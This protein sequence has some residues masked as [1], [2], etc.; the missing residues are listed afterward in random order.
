MANVSVW[1]ANADAQ[2]ATNV[3][4][5]R[6]VNTQ[7]ATEGQQIFTIS[8][9]TYTPGADNLSVYKNG[10]LQTLTTHYTETSISSVTF[11]SG[12]TAGDVVTFVGNSFEAAVGTADNVAVTVDSLSTTVTKAFSTLVLNS[13]AEL[14]TVKGSVDNPKA[15][16]YGVSAVGDAAIQHY[17]WNAS[18]AAADDG[19]L[20]ILPT[21]HLTNGR[22]LRMPTP[23]K[24]TLTEGALGVPYRHI[25]S[26]AFS[27]GST[28]TTVGAIL[29]S[30]QYD[31]AAQ[32]GC[33]IDGTDVVS[34]ITDS[35]ALGRVLY[36]REGSFGIDSDITIT[37]TQIWIGAGLDKTSITG[38]TGNE[39]ISI[40][41]GSLIIIGI[42]FTNL[43]DVGYNTGSIVEFNSQRCKYT[44][45][46]GV[47]R[48]N[49]VTN[50]IAK[51]VFREN[52]IDASTNGLVAQVNTLQEADVCF[53]VITN[54]ASTD[55]QACGIRLGNDVY[56]AQSATPN[57]GRY[58]LIGNRIHGI[59][60]SN[61]SSSARSFGIAVF[62]D[63]HKILGNEVTDITTS[64]RKLGAEGIYDKGRFSVVEG[65]IC[66]DAVQS[67]QGMITLKGDRTVTSGSTTG[68]AKV[69]RG[70]ICIRTSTGEAGFGIWV[71]S[72]DTLVDGNYCEGMKANTTDGITIAGGIGISSST[73]NN[74]SITNNE[75]RDILAN[76]GIYC[77]MAGYGLKIHNNKIYEVSDAEA[78]ASTRAIGI[79][80][81][82]GA[83]DSIEITENDIKI[84]TT[85]STTNLVGIYFAQ[86]QA[87]SNI[88]LRGNN[89]RLADATAAEIG[90]QFA[91]TTAAANKV[92]IEDNDL[93]E[94]GATYDNV[95]LFE[96]TAAPSRIRIKN[97]KWP[98]IQTPGNT[99]TNIARINLPNEYAAIVKA[100]VKAERTPNLTERAWYSNEGLYYRN[101]GG[102]A[103]LQGSLVSSA[104]ETDAL[105]NSTITTV[106]QGIVVTVV[107]LASNDFNWNLDLTVQ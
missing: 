89:I 51:L 104:V 41:G 71:Q 99:V 91:G 65:N 30:Q 25:T 66:V 4:G 21:G 5:T 27:N 98:E 15:I 73:K 54:I 93:S 53:N 82:T 56:E 10:L 59:D 32:T 58:T 17:Y 3:Q 75:L 86:G 20:V 31:V 49:A 60:T 23:T 102:G 63:I 90:I 11:V 19:D 36:F 70:N 44:D 16:V 78:G 12:L 85:D 9:F 74:V 95:I 42:H 43:G 67:I 28:A 24:L 18:S 84:T 96:P 92:D 57:R 1:Q 94:C 38:I 106:A 52:R 7:T 64:V 101:A 46:A 26:G 2:S 37:D 8:G 97:N 6:K 105:L 69:C 40:N 100:V 107:G 77:N 45:V 33:A 47:C 61:A 39:N 79:T 62:G 76:Y 14:R 68:Y 81:Q 103:T 87:N 22:W 55:L 48:S 83:L 72:D 34:A 80:A 29:N 88:K 50:T 13:I 35:M